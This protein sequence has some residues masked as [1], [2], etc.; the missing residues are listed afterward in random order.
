MVASTRD[1]LPVKHQCPDIRDDA[2]ACAPLRA[3]RE[4]F[5]RHSGYLEKL[6]DKVDGIYKLLLNLM[7][8]TMVAVAGWVIALVLYF[9]R[10]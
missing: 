5:Y 4:D 6:F 10:K 8:T 3:L 7:I 2:D 9:A 1:V